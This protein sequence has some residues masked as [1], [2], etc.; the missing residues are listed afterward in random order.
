MSARAIG[1]VVRLFG[2][3]PDT[4]SDYIEC[5]TRAAV[6]AELVDYGWRDNPAVWVYVVTK[7]QTAAEVIAALVVDPDPY[8]DYFV[9]RGP[10]G[11]VR[12]V[13]A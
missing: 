5:A 12:W 4:A 6:E 1:Y 7:G 13:L 2:G 9:E 3:Y 8:P 11:G 10:R